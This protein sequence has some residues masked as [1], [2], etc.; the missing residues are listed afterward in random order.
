MF[1]YAA[2]KGI[3]ENMGYEFCIP[4]HGHD[5]SKYF[6]LDE[7]IIFATPSQ[8]F[9]R[10][11]SGMNFDSKLFNN[12]PDETDLTG[13]FQTEKYFI[14]IREG[15]LKDFSFKKDYAKP[16]EDYIAIHIRR[17]DYVGQPQ[18]HPLCSFD[19]YEKSI[20]M[21][22]ESLPIVVI[23]DD[24]SWCR[25]NINA[26]M[27]SVASAGKDLYIMTQAKYNIIANSSFSWWG[28]WLNARPDKTVIAPKT[29]FGPAYSHYI[30]DD[31][32]P[33]EWIVV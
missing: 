3:A 20:S 18:F 2:L 27:F 28:A 29:W 4:E 16:F 33:E 7:N 15:I 12:C 5:L 25:E 32:I 23:S 19:Y 9:Q 10:G 30:M 13:Y 17:G 22:D 21:I 24:V 1:Q 11:E 14:G 31:L 26:D 8:K 6:K